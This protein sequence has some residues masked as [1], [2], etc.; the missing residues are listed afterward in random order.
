MSRPTAP[1]IVTETP[2]GFFSSYVIVISIRP[3]IGARSGLV[4]TIFGRL[5]VKKSRSVPKRSS[6]SF[7]EGTK[8]LTGIFRGVNVPVAY[9]VIEEINSIKIKDL[10]KQLGDLP[11]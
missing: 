5:P 2:R 8:T 9:S 10:S 3:E 4:I 7:P 1:C 11:P 6:A